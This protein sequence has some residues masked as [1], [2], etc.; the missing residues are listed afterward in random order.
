VPTP[1]T[2]LIPARLGSTRFPAKVLAAETG[3]PLIVHVCEAAAA[4]LGEAAARRLVV[5]TDDERIA[6]EVGRAGF[7]AVM[8]S[9]DHPNGTS[10]LLEAAARLGLG[11]DEV[12]VNVQGDEPEIEPAV[13]RGAVEGLLGV[14]GASCGTVA[15]PFGPDED[16]QRPSVVK[17]ALGPLDAASGTARAVYFSRAAVPFPRDPQAGPG[18]L[19][20]VGLY[21]YCV[22]ALRR[23]AGLA[24]TPLER[25]EGLEQLRWLEHGLT[26]GVAVRRASHHGVD[27]PEDYAAFVARW[28]R[29]TP[30]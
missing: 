17:A 6:A 16:P 7:E 29:R 25:T 10:R 30:G 14:P 11:D 21:A 28:R 1:F 4:C 5:A 22:A 3:R 20:H 26:I 19:K 9:P 24:P 23:Y 27:T 15:S 8:T 18:F 2:I 13:I 12:V